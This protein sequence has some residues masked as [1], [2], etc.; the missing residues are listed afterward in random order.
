M[1]LLNYIDVYA[2][3]IYITFIM[4]VIPYKL[5]HHCFRHI[6]THNAKYNVGVGCLL[7]GAS[8]QTVVCAS[9][10]SIVFH[11]VYPLCFAYPFLP[12]WHI[13]YFFLSCSV[14]IATQSM[15]TP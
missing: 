8:V 3:L 15:L 9:N 5:S 12:V 6:F 2:Y 13:S 14:Y 1:F 4:Y 10:C 7:S 11:G